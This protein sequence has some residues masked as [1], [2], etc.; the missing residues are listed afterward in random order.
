MIFHNFSEGTNY[1]LITF[2]IAA[3][4]LLSI[5]L[6]MAIFVFGKEQVIKELEEFFTGSKN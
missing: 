1:E 2:L 3:P 6:F 5:I 4:V